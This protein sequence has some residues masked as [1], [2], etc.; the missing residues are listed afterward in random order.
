MSIRY[1][2]IWRR[3]EKI[4][5]DKN[6]EKGLENISNKQATLLLFCIELYRRSKDKKYDIKELTYNY[7]LEHIMPQTWEEHWNFEKV[8]HP[9]NK[10]SEEQKR[11]D[12]KSK[13]YWLG[14]MT[15]LKGKLNA[16][17]KNYGFDKKINGEGRKKGM[18][19]YSDLSI[20][21]EIIEA[22]DNGDKNWNEQKIEK[23]TQK[24]K[25]E[26]KEIWG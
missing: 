25:E 22:F 2:L 24:L 20:T 19:A 13:I 26:L 5:F 4:K 17:L 23:R 9:D 7:S 12:R 1:Q 3:T 14:N 11:D 6:V 18:R 16:S 10:L 8:P 15:L 21:K